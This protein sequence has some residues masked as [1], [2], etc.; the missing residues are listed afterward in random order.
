MG[1]ID[2]FVR[3]QENCWDYVVDGSISSQTQRELVLV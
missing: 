3:T 1:F 2:G